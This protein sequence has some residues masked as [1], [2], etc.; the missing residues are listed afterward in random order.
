MTRFCHTGFELPLRLKK[1]RLIQVAFVLRASFLI[2]VFILL[3]TH[4]ARQR[5]KQT[6]Q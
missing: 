3:A 4:Q 2:R 1:S 6:Q 5:Q